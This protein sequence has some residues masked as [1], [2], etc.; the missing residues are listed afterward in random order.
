MIS[1]HEKFPE[2]QQGTTKV[3]TLTGAQICS[4]ELTF[5]GEKKRFRQSS[6]CVVNLYICKYFYSRERDKLIQRFRLI[7]IIRTKRTCKSPDFSPENKFAGRASSQA[8]IQKM[9]QKEPHFQQWERNLITIHLSF[10]NRFNID[11]QDQH[12]QV[13]W[14]QHFWKTGNTKYT[15]QHN[16]NSGLA[17]GQLELCLNTQWETN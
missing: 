15:S 17:V 16:M 9:K 1:S 14:Y 11:L 10:M 2:S 8:L 3:W 4:K 7:R 5:S 6:S 13:Q 12:Y